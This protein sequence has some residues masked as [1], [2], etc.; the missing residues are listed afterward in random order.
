MNDNLINVVVSFLQIIFVCSVF[1][2]IGCAVEWVVLRHCGPKAK[3]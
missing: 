3:E 1:A 2:S